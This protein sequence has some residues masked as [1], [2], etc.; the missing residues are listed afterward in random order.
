MPKALSILLC[1]PLLFPWTVQGIGDS[2]AYFEKHIRPLLIKHCYQ[3]HS[4]ESGKAKGGLQLDSREGWSEGGDSGPAITP[5]EPSHSLLLKAVSYKNTDLQMPPEKRLSTSDRDHLFE[6]IAQ[7]AYDP[8][9]APTSNSKPES[10]VVTSDFWSFRPIEKSQKPPKNNGGDWSHGPVDQF[11]AKEH[12]AE[13]IK[14]APDADIHTALRRLWVVLTGLPPSPDEIDVFLNDD[15]VNAWERQTDRLLAS[16]RYGEHW[17]RHWLDVTRF[18]ESSGGGRSLMFKEAW[19]FRD[20]VI[21]AFNEDIPHNDLIREHLAGDIL[22]QQDPLNA[23]R[24][25]ERLVATGFLALGPTNYE[26]QDKELLRMEVIDEQ[27]DTMGR[28]FLGMTLGCARCHD[29]KFDP[30]ST[31][32]Y[33]ALAGIFRST[34]T[35]TPGNVSG[36]VETPLPGPGYAAQL[37]YERELE[38]RRA[39]LAFAERKNKAQAKKLKKA[40]EAFKKTAPPSRPKVMSVSEEDPKEIA[41]CHVHIRGAIRNLG[42]PVKRGFLIA[43]TPKGQSPH[44]QLKATASGRQALS[45][46]LTHS[47]NPL[48]T[49]VYVNRL[50]HHVF[51]QGLVR[52]VDNFGR[53]GETPSHPELLDYLASEFQTT[54]AWST[55]RLVRD[56]VISK[57]FLLGSNYGA[58]SGDPENRLLARAHSRALSAESLR[59][60]ILQIAGDLDLAVGG[61]TISK[62]S[63]YDNGYKFGKF[64]RRAVYAPAFRNA[65]LEILNLFDAANPN[66]TQGRRTRTTLATQALFL[67][68]SPLVI[69][70]AEAVATQLA[71][72]HKSPITRLEAAYRHIL[73]RGPTSQE[74]EVALTYLAESSDDQ[75][76]T[77]LIQTLFASVDFRNLH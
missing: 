30:V 41:D 67:M 36:F 3:C 42:K 23:P 61:L 59:D 71:D 24:Q 51:G 69:A 29:H 60:A 17:G 31:E 19:R 4:H 70:Q 65:R 26:L 13:G 35:I 50:W 6:W 25:S 46:W 63:A 5:G 1:L 22:F 40:I 15:S 55:K 7:G 37:S 12:Q 72:V 68:N 64:R 43:A 32:E 14:P 45:D 44:P 34:K 2:A 33:Y 62:F 10:N 18:A 73:S 54:G 27:I 49:R 20:Y 39:Q 58:E 38:K 76:W 8:R 21:D 56:L 48:T 53:T 16:P 74:R 28:A 52:T 66:M 75:A 77:A 11:L 9:E 57:A 47:G